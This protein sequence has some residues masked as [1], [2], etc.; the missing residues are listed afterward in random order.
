M[1]RYLIGFVMAMYTQTGFAACPQNTYKI[2]E[3]TLPDGRISDRC[4]CDEKQG[5]HFF[6]GRCQLKVAIEDELIQHI[7]KINTTITHVRGSLRHERNT[8]IYTELEEQ[9]M[10][11]SFQLAAAAAVKSPEMVGSA[12]L[13]VA[14]NLARVLVKYKRCEGND[15]VRA[16]C[17]NLE[18]LQKELINSAKELVGLRSK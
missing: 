13:T 12:A 14:G 15:N 8:L 7:L 1:R 2:G 5:Y 6:R 3:R 4:R 18:T 9:V 11:V 17:R 16:A 10:P